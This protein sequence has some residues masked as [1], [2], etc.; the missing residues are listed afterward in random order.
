I[1]GT[2][3]PWFRADVGIRGDAIA[4]VGDL[5]Q[6]KARRR[7]Q[8]HDLAVSPGFIDMLGQSEL[9]ALIDPREESKVRQG[10]T[11]ELTGEGVSPAPMN[12]AWVHEQQPWL[13]KY[14]LKVGWK[15]LAGYFRRLRRA[16]PSIN[17]AVLVGAAQVRGV[18]LG[19]GDVQPTPAQLERMEKLVDEAMRQ[20]AFGVSTGLIYQPGS[21]ARTPELIALARVAARHHGFYASHIRSEAKKIGEA[22]DEAFTIGRE[23]GVPVEIWHLKVSGRANWG[24]MKEVVGRIEAARASGLDVTANMYPYLASANGLDASIPD[25]AHEGGVDAMLARIRDPAQRARMVR[26]IEG[27]L[28]P[29]DILILA[30]VDPEVKKYAGKRLDEVAKEMGKPP[31]EALVDLV[32]MDKA[33]VGVAR[34]GMSEDDVKLGLAQPWVSLDTDYGGMGIDGPFA[35]EGSAHPRAFGSAAR[36]LGRY[37]RDERLFTVEEAVRKMT[38]LPARRLGL[39]DRGLVRPGMK[40]DLV[41]FDPSTVRDT[42]TFEKPF[43]YP[44]GIPYVLVNGKLVLDGGKRTR[45]RPGRPLLHGEA[46]SP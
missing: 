43:A 12:A 4:A 20:G 23:A 32:A 7:I 11:T 22:L 27:D 28:H 31:A 25:W 21:F 13:D 17:E 34:F 9:N 19:F 2:G 40:A 14:H 15:D 18:V 41:V 8:L 26:E 37:A 10:I 6:A 42:A 16:R 44:E 45:A 1:D 36:M 39:P 33:N 30:A 24:R 38:S 29:E 5:S 35:A 46:S 3:A